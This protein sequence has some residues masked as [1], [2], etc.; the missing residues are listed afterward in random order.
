MINDF[1]MISFCLLFFLSTSIGLT[2]EISPALPEKIKDLISEMKFTKDNIS[3][4]LIDLDSGQEVL[5]FNSDTQIIPA[6]LSKILTTYFAMRI[7]GENY[8]FKTKLYHD[9][10]I[11]DG[12]LNGNLYFVGDGDPI[13]SNADLMNFVLA[14]KSKG[15]KKVN[16]SYYYDQRKYISFDKISSIGLGDQTYNPG[17]SALSLEFNRFTLWRGGHRFKSIKSQF[18]PIPTL[19]HFNISKVSENFT[20]GLRFRHKGYQTNDPVLSPELWEVSNYQRYNIIEEVPVRNPA[21]YAAGT[22]RM[23]AEQMGLIIPEAKPIPNEMSADKV[24]SFPLIY[25]LKS[26]PVHQIAKANMEYSNNLLSEL[27]LLA[28]DHKT[29]PSPSL[30]KAAEK[31]I[32]WYKKEFPKLDFSKTSFMN[33]SGLDTENK[34]KAKTLSGLIA[35]IAQKKMENYFYLSFFSISGQ[36]GWLTKRL[37]DPEMNFRVFAKTG[38]LD[39]INNLAGVLFSKNNK[40]YAFT[41]SLYDFPKR[42]ALN[43]ENNLKVNQLMENAKP[44]NRDSKPILDGILRYFHQTL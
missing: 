8:Q 17:V 39:Y 26:K 28:A 6:S 4:S 42:E 25:Q 19:S 2:Q 37:H 34:I 13:L 40:T 7:L 16:G 41:L 18:T 35:N 27:L 11:K 22:L 21:P 9:G 30:P 36:S 33:G 29:G 43:G 24:K 31:M 15:I 5:S 38:S 14:L 3:Y 20:P 1:R 32:T 12:V 23:L 10:K 44:W